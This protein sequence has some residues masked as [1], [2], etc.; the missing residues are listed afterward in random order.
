MRTVL[1]PT[2]LLTLATGTGLHAQPLDPL[3]AQ[4]PPALPWELDALV[5]RVQQT[6]DAMQDFA[7]R[8]TQT[9]TNTALDE[10]S[11]SGG[12]VR[13]M[14]PGRM[15]WDYTRPDIRLFLIDG[16]DLWIYE[17]AQAQYYTQ[18]LDESDLPT[19]LRFLTGEGR[20]ADDFRISLVRQ[21]QDSALL[22]LVPRLPEG[23]YQKL[24][25]R[26]DLQSFQIRQ[27]ILYDPLGNTNTFSFDDWEP[28][29][30]F[31]AEDFRFVPPPGVRRIE[32]PDGE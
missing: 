21:D 13:Y 28:N 20:L 14:R 18:P 30:G 12:W 6:C 23:D 25:L 32:H 5:E 16:T 7:A 31:T 19:A 17:P 8:F 29:Q 15:R 2:L 24:R 3:Q 9:Y 10:S 1:I 22:E 27:T 26:V 11:T 4:A